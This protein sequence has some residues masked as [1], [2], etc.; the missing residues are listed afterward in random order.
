M[1]ARVA[2]DPS[3]PAKPL[4]RTGKLPLAPGQYR[5]VTV[6]LRVPRGHGYRIAVDLPDLGQSLHADCTGRDR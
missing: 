1:A 3:G 6:P 2:V 5:E 4:R